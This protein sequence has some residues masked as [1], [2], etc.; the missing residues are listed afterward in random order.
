MATAESATGHRQRLRE[1]F[2]AGEP[3]ALTEESLVEL[4][5]T[6]AIP[7]K[8]VQP[9]A[10]TLIERFGSVRAVLEAPPEALREVKGVGEATVV[11]LRLV[12]RLATQG[13]GRRTD[14]RPVPVAVQPSLFPPGEVAEPAREERGQ[15]QPARSR[16]KEGRRAKAQHIP[17]ARQP[18]LFGK[19]LLKDAIEIAPRLPDTESLDEVRKLVRQSLHYSS[20]QTRQR[21]AAYIVRR[22]FPDGDVDRALPLF[23]RKFAGT[24]AL[25]DACFYRFLKAEPVVEQ[26]VRDLLVPA[27]G[28][29]S[30]P[31]ATVRAYLAE[32]FPS[33]QPRIIKDTAMG[34]AQALDAAGLAQAQRQQLVFGWRNVALEAFAFVLHSE[35]P[36]PGMYD[37]AR[38][39]IGPVFQA[40]L[41]RPEQLLRSLYELRNR[42]LIAKVSEIDSVRQFTTSHDLDGLVRRLV[43]EEV[44]A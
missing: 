31:R 30:L 26:C 18:A 41:W 8:D 22:L 16:A 3:R 32:R 2:L 14:G 19:A 6:F 38:V 15:P 5:L 4:L 25:R 9:L 33:G 37:V 36:R 29:G 24:Q 7:Q 13:E 42:G 34:I 27:A 28:R 20:D 11:L 39:E 17:E 44:A 10:R 40:F 1:R 35:F 12:R 21:Y 23:A 43:G